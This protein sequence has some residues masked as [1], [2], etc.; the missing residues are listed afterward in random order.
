VTYRIAAINDEVETCSRCGKS[1]LKRVAWV[2]EAEEGPSTAAPVGLDCASIIMGYGQRKQGRVPARAVQ[3]VAL[4]FY[5]DKW[6]TFLETKVE[7]AVEIVPGFMLRADEQDYIFTAPG[8]RYR[9]P[10]C[11][12][13]DSALRHAAQDY[14][15]DKM[16]ELGKEW[17]KDTKLAS[18]PNHHPDW[19]SELKNRF[20]AMIVR[21]AE[22]T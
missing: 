9:G 6:R 7:V 11:Y 3:Q 22:A 8:F 2:Y 13:L 15:R 12:G 5:A 21:E 4:S 10:A 1:G 20:P 16:G 19:P 18:N 14:A 17:R